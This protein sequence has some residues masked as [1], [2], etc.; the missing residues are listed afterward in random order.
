M[1][2]PSVFRPVKTG[3][4]IRV[5][6]ISI[7]RV[8]QVYEF[9]IGWI[10]HVVVDTLEHI[11]NSGHCHHQHCFKGGCSLWMPLWLS[12]WISMRRQ[13]T[14]LCLR[15]GEHSCSW[16]IIPGKS[17]CTIFTHSARV[18]PHKFDSGK[19]ITTS[20]VSS[21]QIIAAATEVKVFP[22][23]I[24]SA[25]RA[26]GISASQTHL[27][28]MN[29]IAQ[30][31]CARHL[32]PGRPGNE[33]L[34][35]GTLSSVEWRIWWAFSSL[36]ASSRHWCSNSL[37]IVLR[38]VLNTELVL[39]RSRISSPFTCSWTYLAPWLVFISSSMI[40]VSCSRVW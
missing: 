8:Q 32:V 24:S 19:P 7:F 39:S 17:F 22:R 37:L 36:T 4:Q 16:T 34:W 3:V 30:T 33:Y 2:I 35:P 29:H 5:G 21:L 25:T 10:C 23:P 15:N 27:L 1:D 31:W 28:T 14:E 6:E 26:P 11:C 40:S 20:S 12:S 38:R 13:G 9:Q 18:F